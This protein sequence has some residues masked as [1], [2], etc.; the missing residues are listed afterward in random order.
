MDILLVF[1][2]GLLAFVSPC[3]LPML[4]VY[5]AYLAGQEQQEDGKNK[6]LIF[7]TLGFILGFTIVF[8][9]M[10]ATATGIGRILQDY[11]LLIQ[12]ISG[13]III[14]FGLHYMGVFKIGFLNKDTRFS[15]KEKTK[16]LTFIT[17]ILFGM[18]FSFGWTPCI[19]PL[20]GSAL[21]LAANKATIFHGMLLLLVFSAGLGLPFF[22]SALILDKLKSVFN[23]IKKHMKVIT[24]ISGVLL[25]LTGLALVFDVFGYWAGLFS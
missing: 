9:A 12:R 14:I 15:G 20:L 8:V 10:G 24:I 11:R 3:I 6:S 19:G 25:I 23:F 17:S 21:V 1:F 16:N 5:I 7:N 22:L 13:I 2:E 4:P 18:A